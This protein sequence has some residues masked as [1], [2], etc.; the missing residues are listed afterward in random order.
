[1]NSEPT[2]PPTA[3]RWRWAG[4]V[5]GVLLACAATLAACEWAGWPF[6]RAPLQ[7]AMAHTLQV[8]VH[9]DGADFRVQL[10]WRPGLRAS[11][12]QIGSGAGL[13]LPHLLLARDVTLEWRW[14]DVMRWRG[15]EGLRV[16]RLQAGF[17]DARLQR[18][19]D[20]RASWHLGAP[21][22]PTAPREGDDVLPQLP[23]FGA[24]V[25]EQGHIELDDV[26]LRT[27][28]RIDIEGTDDGPLKY[29]ARIDGRYRALPLR[30]Q[31]R[32]GSP[33]PL[34][35]DGRNAPAVP[36]QVRGTA[37][38]TTLGFDG[39]AAALL[40]PR[41]LQG[42]VTLRGPSLANPARLLGLTLPSTPPFEFSGRIAHAAG[43]WQLQVARARIG[44]SR[45]AGT[46]DYDSR[47]TPPRLSGRL[48][49]PS[50]VLTD[51]GPA[52]GTRGEAAR[53]QAGRVLP[54]RQ[55]DLPSLHGMDADVA[56]SIDRLDF[57]T[58]AVAPLEPLRTRLV[59]DDG[60]LR[61]EDL[62]VGQGASRVA[63][64]MRLNAHTRPA[65]WEADLRFNVAE[66]ADWLPVLRR[67]RGGGS[68]VPALTGAL[69]GRLQ[70]AGDGRSTAEILSSLRGR[71]RVALRD[72]SV[73]HL[74]TEAAGLDL[75]Q[76][77]GVMIRGDR[78]LPLQC[79]RLDLAIDDGI[80]R[81]RVAIVENRDSRIRIEGQVNL[82]TEVLD[83][84]ATVKPKDVSPLSL[85]S[86]IRVTGT[87]ADPTVGVD[88]GRLAGRALGAL[89]LGAAVA[90]LAALLPLIDIGRPPEQ[91]CE[92]DAAPGAA[93]SAPG[94]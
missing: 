35:D 89:A 39:Q 6:L 50:L 80:V 17:V 28:L 12:L 3:R 81:P 29:L 2:S 8:P 22:E 20:G 26:P 52:V 37:G 13:P 36:M 93:A 31:V 32:S 70:V 33:L 76:A 92:V 65:R 87:L 25:V 63:G 79:A 7:R 58:E 77:L 19:A 88:G 59:L 68:S 43:L 23:Q 57:D 4:I 61:L 47:S 72:G 54:Q 11:E 83:L 49:G 73:S 84:R 40:G 16:Q 38:D 69:G 48:A 74:L 91:P 66:L 45:L 18:L 86:P 94:R 30:L 34:L 71:A 90:P 56:I 21:R 53:P 46:F 44:R 14:S 24:F 5:G 1:M 75:A 64:T 42:Q 9:V 78:P 62:R 55:F 41:R 82:A 10:L 67:D 60:V 51:L 15:G 27:R 85:R